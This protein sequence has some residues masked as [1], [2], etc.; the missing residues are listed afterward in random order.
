MNPLVKQIVVEIADSSATGVKW[1]MP[2][3]NG[4]SVKDITAVAAGAEA[5]ALVIKLQKQT[6][7]GVTASAVD[8]ATVTF[9]A[10]DKQGLGYA[11][12]PTAALSQ[13]AAGTALVLNVTTAST[14]NK[15]VVCIIRYTEAEGIVENQSIVTLQ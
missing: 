15:S 2:I 7:L 9:P 11:D 13:L 1:R 6:A 4:I 3:L 8:L 12:R 5:T 10:S 14:A